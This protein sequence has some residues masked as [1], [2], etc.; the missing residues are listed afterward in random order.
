M[1]EQIV[2][3]WVKHTPTERHYHSFHIDMIWLL[4]KYRFIY[5]RKISFTVTKKSD[6]EEYTCTFYAE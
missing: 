5:G 2:T 1:R 6:C 4:I 3:F